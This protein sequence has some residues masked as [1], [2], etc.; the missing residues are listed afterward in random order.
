MPVKYWSAAGLMLTSWCNAAC[1][2][3]YLCCS[4]RRG[5]TMSVDFGLRVWRELQATSPHGCRVHLSGGEPFGDWERLVE[6]CTRACREGLG[7]PEKIETNAFWAGDAAEVRRRV[8]TLDKLGMGKLVISAD[9][10]HQQFVP[11]ERCR[12][13]ARVAEE[14]IGRE[15]VQVRW[16]DWLASGFNT[17]A[18]SAQRRKLLFARWSGDGRDRLNARAAEMLGPLGQLKPVEEFVDCSCSEALLRS[19]HVHVAPE[20][21]VIPGTCAGIVLGRAERESIGEIWQRL[22]AEYPRRRVVGRL[23]ADGP[24]G[25][26][27]DACRQGFQPADGYAS[28]CHLCSEVRRFLFRKGLGGWELSPAWIYERQQQIA[29]DANADGIENVE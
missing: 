10:Y 15:R 26:L 21:S 5:E 22:N 27:A 13:A 23:S 1:A 19:K 7:G 11:I 8:E 9:P 12:L 24:A 14:V 17:D 29:P 16:R 20:G 4:S 3:C 25:L 18:L 6:L 28:K 2:S